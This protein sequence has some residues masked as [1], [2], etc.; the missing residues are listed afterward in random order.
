[1]SQAF[2]VSLN[3]TACPS[4]VLTIVPPHI[5]RKTGTVNVRSRVVDLRSDRPVG[6]Y[7]TI[8]HGRDVFIYPHRGRR[9]SPG[10]PLVSKT[11]G[12][13]ASVARLVCEFSKVVNALLNSRSGTH[14]ASSS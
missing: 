5:G 13:V 11:R 14:L 6:V 12:F 3:V 9:H 2:L 8:R 4:T 7:E 10:L 1:M